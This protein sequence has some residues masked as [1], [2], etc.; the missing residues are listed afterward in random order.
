LNGGRLDAAVMERIRATSVY[1]E[2]GTLSGY[3]RHRLLT[4]ALPIIDDAGMFRGAVII[5]TPTNA[6][7]QLFTNLLRGVF[8]IALFVLVLAAALIYFVSQNFT[9]PIK[10]MAAAARSFSRGDF[11]A[12][13]RVSGRDEVAELAR[14]FNSMADSLGKLEQLRSEFIANVSHELKTP[15]TTIG[16]FVDG[17][18]DGTIPKDREGYY[19]ASSVPRSSACRA[20]CKSYCWPRACNRACRISTSPMSISPPL[21]PLPRSVP[22]RRS[23]KNT[24]TSTSTCPNPASLSAPMPMRSRRSSPT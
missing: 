19:L 24:S 12:R 2:V 16:G 17:I 20:L 11:S 18:I 5:S 15:M 13:V 10:D 4:V 8:L 6:I 1:K 21:S 22:S 3:F 23:R 7:T 9:R 14:S